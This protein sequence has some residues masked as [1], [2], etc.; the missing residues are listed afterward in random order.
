MASTSPS[1]GREGVRERVRTEWADRGRESTLWGNTYTCDTVSHDTKH[2]KKK[3]MLE[4]F[5]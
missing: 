1:R 2:R 4:S 5:L 3:G